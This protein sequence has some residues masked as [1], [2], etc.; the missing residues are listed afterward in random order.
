MT[1]AL[2]GGAFLDVLVGAEHYGAYEVL[3]EVHR[4][5]LHAVVEFKQL[6]E[7]ALF[8][9]VDTHDTVAD[10]NDRAH[11]RKLQL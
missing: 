1:G 10:G 7:H 9:P 4:H 2:D 5:A 11:V 3:L 8:K 6:V